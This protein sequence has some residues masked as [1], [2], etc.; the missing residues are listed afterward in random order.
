MV[1]NLT[2]NQFS[3][4]SQLD[5][6][7]PPHLSALNKSN[8]D[9]E[10]S[11][12]NVWVP[13]SNTPGQWIQVDFSANRIV[14]EVDLWARIGIPQW[15]TSFKLALKRDGGDF[16]FKFTPNGMERVFQGPQRHHNIARVP[17]DPTEARYVRL[18]PQTYHGYMSVIWEI[19]ACDV[20]V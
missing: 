1:Q 2:E 18:Y 15:V 7:H 12:I 20:V 9:P 19:Y 13:L 17:I 16:R 14:A 10:L 3:A 4:S 6:N 11:H 5:G 8:P